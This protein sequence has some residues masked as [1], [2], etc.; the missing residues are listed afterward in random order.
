MLPGCA[1]TDPLARYTLAGYDVPEGYAFPDPADLGDGAPDGMRTNPGRFNASA[2]GRVVPG[3]P[4][5]ATSGYAAYL[6]GTADRNLT[7]VSVAVRL[8]RP[9]EAP[10]AAVVVAMCEA[11]AG[12]GTYL[13]DG[14]VLSSFIWSGGN[15]TARLAQEAI[16]QVERATSAQRVC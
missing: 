11:E 16:A 10:E 1:M 12:D 14:D 6:Q 7:I 13:L 2:I 15:A 9:L 8:S 3:S 4:V 5:N